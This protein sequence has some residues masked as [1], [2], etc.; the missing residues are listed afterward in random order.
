[1]NRSINRAAIAAALTAGMAFF[2]CAKSNS[3]TNSSPGDSPVVMNLKVGIGKVGILA[4]PAG[5]QG[6]ALSKTSSISLAK[7][8]FE[9]TSNTGDTLRD[10]LTTSS[11]P[12]SINAVSTS[13]QTI[14]KDYS[15]LKPLRS[16]KL[17]A[18]TRDVNDSIIQKDSVVSPILYAG[19]TVDIS[20]NLNSRYSMYDAKFLAIPDSIS[21]SVPGTVKQELIINRLVFKIDGVAQADSTQGG[22]FTPLDTAILSY[23][24]VT[25]GS[26]NV[27]LEAW[28][29][30]NPLHADSLLFTGT[31]NI[32]AGTGL[33]SGVAFNLGWVGPTTGTGHISA[34]I[35]K[36]GK[37]TVNGALP[38]TV[39]P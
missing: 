4:K 7:L 14:V 8:I 31:Q 28:G 3:L 35:G 33:D 39:I 1:M 11:S 34:T 23:D 26:H 29:R 17:V 25:V 13:P 20:L 19:D 15:G 12:V 10:T 9:L 37:I 2:G 24:Y 22:G 36:V 30:I 32:N 21:S 6:G 38:G 27:T 5:M 16:W 18:T